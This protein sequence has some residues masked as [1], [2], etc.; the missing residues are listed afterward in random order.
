MKQKLKYIFHPRVIIPTLL[1]AA[2]L[3]FLLT[4]ANSGQ[5]GGDLLR[6]AEGVWLPALLL[7]VVYLAVKLLQWRLYLGRL[8]LKPGWQEVLVPYAGGEMSNS[9]PM[10]VYLE[11]YLLKGSTGSAVGRSAAATTWMLITEVVTC[12]LALLVL[13]VPGWPWVRPVAAFLA[14]GMLLVGFFFFRTRFVAAWLEKWQP[15]RSALRL[16]REGMKE[17]LEGSDE[18]FSWRTFATGLPLC[19]VYL[20]AQATILYVVGNMLVAPTQPWTWTD[21]ATAYAFSLVIVLLVPALPQLGSVEVSGLGV[22]LQFGISKNLAVGSF[23]A[24]RLLA[25]GAIILVCGLVLVALHRELGE[26]FRR[27]SRVGRPGKKCYGDEGY[28]GREGFAKGMQNLDG[29]PCDQGAETPFP[30]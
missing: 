8:G 25:T 17:F 21:A 1:S 2:F 24:V 26:T 20:G 19:A 18:L 9:L 23:L 29:E 3:A 16:A 6:A 30:T 7:A 14:V 22:M 27:L 15:H 13:G 28:I 11:N 10:G 12:L 5:V 4:F